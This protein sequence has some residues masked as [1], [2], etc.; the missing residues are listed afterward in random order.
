MQLSRTA[1]F[2]SVA[3]L[4]F[5]VGLAV[6]RYR[7]FP[8]STFE[9]GKESLDTVLMEAAVAAGVR[10]SEHSAPS[11]HA[12]RGVTRNETARIVPG[13]TLLSGFFDGHNEL[14]LVKPDGTVVNRWAASFSQ[15]FPDPS[16]IPDKLVPQSDISV[17][18][19]GAV[20]LPDGSVVF[21]FDGK[22]SVKLDRCGRIDW[23]V[24]R[25]THHAVSMSEDGRFW[26]P[27]FRYIE[28]G[29]RYPLLD[30]PFL[31]PTVLKVGADGDVEQEVSILELFFE[32][33]LAPVLFAN[34][35]KGLDLANKHAEPGLPNDIVHLNDVEELPSSMAAAFPQFHPGSLLLSMRDYNLVMVADPST[36]EVE[37]YRVGPWIGQHDP[38]FMPNGHISVFDN[39]NDG[40]ETGTRLG[41]SRIVE[42]DPATGAY[43]VRYGRRPDQPFFTDIMG[44]HQRLPGNMLIA[45]ARAG[46]VIEVTEKGEIVWEFINRADEDTVNNVTGA[47]R[48]PFDYFTVSDWAC[49]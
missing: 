27:S 33:D 10:D 2:A 22:G 15:A 29:D 40:T 8:Y 23:T 16:Y 7:V 49:H 36:R 1:F 25:L 45:E 30:P 44:Q 41:G 13:L 28:S 5:L 4:I 14:R 34:G 17:G 46:R 47:T 11:R 24:P 42:I 35:L 32:N 9:Y 37:W 26:I 38:D 12:G 31:E 19:H 20:A 6:G 39:A 48:Y 3:A 43:V 18:I 21:N